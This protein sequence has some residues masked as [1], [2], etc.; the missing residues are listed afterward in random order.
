[1]KDLPPLFKRF[2]DS[3]EHRTCKQCRHVM[4]PKK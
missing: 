3:E 1:V 4:P 2:W